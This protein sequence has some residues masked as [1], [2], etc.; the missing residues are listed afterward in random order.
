MKIS[1]F[2][3]S[4]LNFQ[5]SFT[6]P[7][8][9]VVVSIIIILVA[10]GVF[11]FLTLQPDLQLSGISRELIA[12]LRYAQQLTVTEQVDH[13]IHFFSLENKYQLIRYG[14]TEEI[15]KEKLLSGRIN[16]QEISGFTDDTVKFN[17]YGAARETGTI[18]LINTNNKTKIIEIRPSGF[19]KISD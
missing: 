12:D 3:L 10:I 14:A 13:G 18:T 11:T 6:L 9:L 8:I 16:F 2:E 19:V 7:E 5:R 4:I 15:L 1:N 17:P